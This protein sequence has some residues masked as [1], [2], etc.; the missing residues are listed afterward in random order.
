MPYKKYMIC[1]VIL[2]FTSKLFLYP[3]QLFAQ[4]NSCTTQ[5]ET[6]NKH[7]QYLINFDTL[8]ANKLASKYLS[9]KGA[10]KGIGFF[11][12]IWNLIDKRDT[13]ATNKKSAEYLQYLKAIHA[14][15]TLY[16]VY[17]TIKARK[18]IFMDADYPEALSNQLNAMRIFEQSMDTALYAQNLIWTCVT[19]YRM[20]EFE[21]M[22]ALRSRTADLL[23]IAGDYPRKAEHLCILSSMYYVRKGE[24]QH[25]KGQLD[26]AYFFAKMAIEK[27]RLFKNSVAELDGYTALS[28]IENFRKNKVM[29]LAYLDSVLRKAQPFK[30]DKA[31]A[32]AYQNLSSIYRKQDDFY[33]AAKYADSAIPFF[34]RFASPLLLSSG[35]STQYKAYKG[36]GDF[37]KALIAFEAST[38]INDSLL[39]LE[40]T[41]KI[42]ELEQKYNQSKNEQTIL[43]LQHRQQMYL[44]IAIISL[45]VVTIAV[46]IMRQKNFQQ[47]QKILEAEQRLNR[48]RMNP[49]FFFNALAS[50][51]ELAH[52]K[53]NSMELVSSLAKFS[54]IMRDTLES[55]YKEFIVL[56]DEMDFLQQYLSLQQLRLSHGFAFD[57]KANESIETDDVAIPTMIIQPFVENAIEHGLNN[58]E[59]QGNLSII[60]RQEN[61]NLIVTIDDNGTGLK[62][63]NNSSPH[64]SRAIQIIKD[65]IYL[66]NTSLKTNAS[67]SINNKIHEAGVQVKITLPL[68]HIHDVSTPPHS[69]I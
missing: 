39:S 63:K 4:K 42:N 12:S 46:F 49:H 27:A 15:S 64:I 56:Q 43:L 1:L 13:T 25:T 38:K 11:L 6:I 57:I 5:R 41:K 33:T 68:L 8:S 3:S 23:K 48:A 45:M 53:S 47:K 32:G 18:Y 28:A 67:F 30:H 59:K 50:L 2:M 69:I 65:R 7:S 17:Y 66:L 52:E 36:L 29:A 21:K 14:D 10:C 60:F 51:Q 9:E 35:Y 62:E 40:K 22:K 54:H 16:A 61:K 19:W 34:I 58:K 26:T 31:I 37:Q 44:F 55:T 24:E 20:G